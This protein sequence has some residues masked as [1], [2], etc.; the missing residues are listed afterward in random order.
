MKERSILQSIPHEILKAAQRVGLEDESKRAATY[1]AIDHEAIAEAVSEFYRGQVEIMDIRKALDKHS[2]VRKLRWKLISPDKD[3]HTKSVE[4][5]LGGGYF[6]RIAPGAKLILPLQTCLLISTSGFEQKLHNIIIAEEG[7]E[8]TVVTGCT[9]HPR[10]HSGKHVGVSEFYVKQGAKLH[11]AMLHAWAREVSVHP[12]SAALVEDGAI[13]VSSYASLNPLHTIDMHPLILCEGREATAQSNILIHA[14][15]SAEMELGEEAVLRGEGARAQLISRIVARDEA[16]V[17]TQPM[18][19][20]EGDRAKGHVE[21]K[22]IVLGDGAQIHAVP[23]LWAKRKNVELSHEA[24][25]GRLEEK[26]ITYLMTRGLDE[27]EA[28]SVLIRGFLN[29]RLLQLPSEIEAEVNEL[30][31][32]VAKGL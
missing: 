1:V 5:E 9:V 3:E 25:V 20:G 19:I 26:A 32:A 2:W 6:I 14:V 21:C 16:K 30:I 4:E 28:V 22:G 12:R 23:G 15:G 13:F 10:I 18:L 11:F 17:S 29:P 8:A 27:E 24:A 31:K 7:C